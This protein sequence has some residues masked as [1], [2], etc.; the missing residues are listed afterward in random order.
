MDE[1]LQFEVELDVEILRGKTES[2]WGIGGEK[3]KRQGQTSHLIEKL[4][5]RDK[6]MSGAAVQYSTVQYCS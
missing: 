4:C 3:E 1:M 6:Q 5:R 2:V